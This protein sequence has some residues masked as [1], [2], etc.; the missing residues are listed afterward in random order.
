[1]NKNITITI[2]IL[3][4]LTIVSI[5]TIQYYQ[6]ALKQAEDKNTLLTNNINALND[7]IK[8]IK[9]D[10]SSTFIDK[11]LEGDLESLMKL[12][13]FKNLSEEKQSLYKKWNSSKNQIAGL[14]ST[15]RKQGFI[16]DSLNGNQFKTD[17]GY[18]FAFGDSLMNID[19]NSNLKLSQKITF[20]SSSIIFNTNYTYDLKINTTVSKDS[21]GATIVKYSFNDSAIQLLESDGLVTIPEDPENK[22][23]RNQ[24]KWLKASV[25]ASLAIILLILIL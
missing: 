22:K 3:L 24:N 7:S 12:N 25:P 5:F 19:T 23:L 18:V 17:S 10:T 21:S 20:D 14:Q 2:L 15:I 1:M 11:I 9:T 13:A 16:I 4:I 6:V 8:V